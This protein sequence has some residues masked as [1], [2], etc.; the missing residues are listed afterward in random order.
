[1]AKTWII[2][3]PKN[4]TKLLKRLDSSAKKRYDSLLADFEN[5]EDPSKLGNLEIIKGVKVYVARLNISYRVIY[6]VIRPDKTIVILAIGD[7]KEVFGK[8]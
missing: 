2:R 1:M 8:D 5:C 7:H 6:Y 3:T 4:T